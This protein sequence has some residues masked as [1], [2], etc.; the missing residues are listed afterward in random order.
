MSQLVIE[1][2]SYATFVD[3][4]F[5]SSDEESS[6]CSIYITQH[7]GNWEDFSTVSSIASFPGDLTL[8]DEDCEFSHLEFADGIWDLSEWCGIDFESNTTEE[9]EAEYGGDIGGDIGND[10]FSST[11]ASEYGNEKEEICRRYTKGNRPSVCMNAP[12]KKS[13]DSYRVRSEIVFDMNLQL[14][15][16]VTRRRSH[17]MISFLE[18]ITASNRQLLQPDSFG[19]RRGLPRIS[20]TASI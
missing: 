13:I 15:S 17:G 10:E 9:D 14:F 11:T 8:G 16:H 20:S 19:E 4:C 2:S 12:S 1:E 6:A 7:T 3:E 18:Q 5:S